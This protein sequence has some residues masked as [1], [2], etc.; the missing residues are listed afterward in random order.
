[1]SSER[2]KCSGCDGVTR[3]SQEERWDPSHKVKDSGPLGRAFPSPIRSVG[4]T[5]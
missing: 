5:K 3:I 4:I 2:V 1:M